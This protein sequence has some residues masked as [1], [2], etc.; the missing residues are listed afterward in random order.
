M[1]S[2]TLYDRV[3]VMGPI[4]ISATTVHNQEQNNPDDFSDN[5]NYYVERQEADWLWLMG[6]R[7]FLLEKID[8]MMGLVKKGK[9]V[10]TKNQANY[11]KN[12]VYGRMMQ[13]YFHQKTDEPDLSLSFNLISVLIIFL[14]SSRIWLSVGSKPYYVLWFSALILG[15]PRIQ[16]LLSN[17]IAQSSR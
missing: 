3:R 16:D 11:W 5:Q 15:E 13:L 8:K 12:E 4:P 1:A 14:S 17:F 6:K 2:L 10:R 7:F 9:L